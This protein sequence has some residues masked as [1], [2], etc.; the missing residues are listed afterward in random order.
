MAELG[1][2]KSITPEIVK[3]LEEAFSNAL[4]DVEACLYAGV[5]TSAFYRYCEEHLD[6]REWKEELKKKPNIRAKLNILKGVNAGDIND[7]KWWLER[8]AKDEFGL[9]NEMKVSG[10]SDN[11]LVA[12]HTIELKS[13]L[14]STLSDEQLEQLRNSTG[15]LDD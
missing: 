6:F 11:P 2:P 10:D 1:R 14:L 15:Q 5:S 13:K 9:K 7:S 12:R 8:K 4:T 3:K